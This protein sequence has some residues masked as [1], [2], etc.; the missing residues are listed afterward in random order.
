VT[1]SVRATRVMLTRAF[2]RR[3]DAQ[4]RFRRAVEDIGER[5]KS[6][7]RMEPLTDGHGLARFLDVRASSLAKDHV[8]YVC[9]DA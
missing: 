4:P 9:P 1:T 6:P 8:S 5:F 2:S 3:S 7:Q